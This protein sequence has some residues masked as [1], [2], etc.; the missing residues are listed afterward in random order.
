MPNFKPCKTTGGVDYYIDTSTG[1]IAWKLPDDMVRGSGSAQ[2]WA[3]V[4]DELEGWKAMEESKAPAE[5]HAPT[6]S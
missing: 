2:K 6:G 1:T 5:A 4:E 3:W